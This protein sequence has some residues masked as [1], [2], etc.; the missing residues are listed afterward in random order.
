MSK[1]KYPCSYSAAHIAII[2]WVCRCFRTLCT[3]LQFWLE[4]A[5]LYILFPTT[6]FEFE[7]Y[8]YKTYLQD[9]EFAHRLSYKTKHECLMKLLELNQ[10]FVPDFNLKVRELQMVDIYDWGCLFEKLEACTTLQKLALEGHSHL[11]LDLIA[12]HCPQISELALNIAPQAGISGSLKEYKTMKR[13]TL[14]LKGYGLDYAKPRIF[15]AKDLVLENLLPHNSW[16]TLE[17]LVLESCP[18]L[19]K[20]STRILD[21]F[22]NLRELRVFGNTSSSL[23]SLVAGSEFLRL[24]KLYLSIPDRLYLGPL[25]ELKMLIGMFQSP[26]LSQLEDLSLHETSC[27]FVLYPQPFYWSLMRVILETITKDLTGLKSLNLATRINSDWIDLLK[28]VSTLATLQWIVQPTRPR[29][30]PATADGGMDQWEEMLDQW[31]DLP[32]F[33]ESRGDEKGDQAVN[34]SQ[35]ELEQLFREKYENEAGQGLTIKI[36]IFTPVPREGDIFKVYLYGGRF[37]EYEDEHTELDIL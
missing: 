17:T 22:I 34:F 31:D 7:W 6:S 8:I 27:R 9:D 2:R 24:R 23:Y 10:A 30:D 33:L 12:R 1:D 14:A 25:D 35:K 26:A 29:W 20:C 32:D 37:P 13:L 28:S 36:K 11:N 19:S 3:G 21:S 18:S 15:T 4:L 16:R 5:H